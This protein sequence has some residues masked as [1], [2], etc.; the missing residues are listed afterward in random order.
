MLD[1]PGGKVVGHFTAAHLTHDSP[2][3]AAA[4]SLEIH[5]F[6]LE[7]GSIHGLGMVARGTEGHFLILGGTGRYAGARGSYVA[8]Q[9]VREL[10]GDGTSE[11][12]LTLALTVDAVD[13]EKRVEC[14]SRL[15]SRQCQ[16]ELGRAVAAQL[17]YVLVRDV[18]SSTP[19]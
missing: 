2:F 10:G 7:A 17:A 15:L 1:R 14:H 4:S 9:H 12:H 8:H 16:M 19:A 6:A 11:F 3:A 5:T 13:L 18:A